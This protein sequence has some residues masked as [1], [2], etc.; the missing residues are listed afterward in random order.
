MGR[1]TTHVLDIAAGRP[2]PGMRIVLTDLDGGAVLGEFRTNAD[3][4]LDA[5]ALQG[6]AFKPGRYE[7]LFFVAEYFRA[8]GVT[9]DGVNFLEDVPLRF[10]VA[11]AAQ[12]YHVP[13]LVSPWA[14]STYRGS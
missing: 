6:D 8:Q 5:P 9:G 4:R 10:G 12:H 3:G 7:L 1:L 13:L 14:Y 2:A 11:D